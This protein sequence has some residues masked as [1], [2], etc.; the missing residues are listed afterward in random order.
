MPSS[1]AAGELTAARGTR[2]VGGT[3]S[4]PLESPQMETSIS[5]CVLSLGF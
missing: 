5:D 3:T 2:G 1:G 4:D